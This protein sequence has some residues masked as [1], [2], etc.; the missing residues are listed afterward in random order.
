VLAEDYNLA[1]VA[2]YGCSWFPQCFRSDQTR[3]WGIARIL[4][5]DSCLWLGHTRRSI[6]FPLRT[7]KVWHSNHHVRYTY[8]QDAEKGFERDV[9]RSF[10]LSQNVFDEKKARWHQE[11]G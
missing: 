2:H 11:E 1:G 10:G 5:T 8:H 6:P 3:E 7:L 9:P 4:K